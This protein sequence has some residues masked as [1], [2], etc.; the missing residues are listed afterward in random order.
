MHDKS[1]RKRVRG[2]IEKTMH[3]RM[4]RASIL[5]ADAHDERVVL[6]VHVDVGVCRKWEW[7][8]DT[9]LPLRQRGMQLERL[10]VVSGTR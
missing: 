6:I 9:G 3:H 1:G 2:H 5:L 8:M 10:S 4:V 7:A